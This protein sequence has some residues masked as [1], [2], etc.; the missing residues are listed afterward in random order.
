M[1]ETE[2]LCIQQRLRYKVMLRFLLTTCQLKLGL[3]RVPHR[4]KLISCY[5]VESCLARPCNVTCATPV[6][7]A[8][9]LHHTPWQA[10][11]LC[12]LAFTVSIL[13]S[14]RCILQLDSTDTFLACPPNPKEA[15]RIRFLI[16][17]FVSRSDHYIKP[18]LTKNKN[19]LR[20]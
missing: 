11:L 17:L 15:R 3:F 2:I 16:E 12:L 14:P 19:L 20:L 7:I 6:A 10:K 8:V 1:S 18:C 13:D 5:T 9:K 4:D